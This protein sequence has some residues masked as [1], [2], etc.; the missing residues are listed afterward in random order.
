MRGS[1]KCHCGRAAQALSLIPIQ[2]V[3]DT[4]NV[5]WEASA[6]PFTFNPIDVH[7]PWHRQSDAERDK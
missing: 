2:E 4:P 3:Q 6:T 5:I 7:A 1:C